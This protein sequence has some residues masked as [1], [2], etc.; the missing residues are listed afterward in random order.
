[1]LYALPSSNLLTLAIRLSVDFYSLR[2]EVDTVTNL[3]HIPYALINEALAH[4][5][6]RFLTS[7]SMCQYSDMGVTRS[8][9]AQKAKALMPL[10]NARRI[11][12]EYHV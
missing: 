5:R 12:H 8:L 4:P 7:F 6:F 2:A 9:L 11:L 3:A 1:M 10:A